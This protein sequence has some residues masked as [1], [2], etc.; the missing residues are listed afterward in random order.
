MRV[1][2][3]MCVLWF[4]EL[5]HCIKNGKDRI[6]FWITRSLGVDTQLPHGA[7]ISTGGKGEMVRLEIK[8][9]LFRHGATCHRGVTFSAEP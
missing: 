5:L 6:P 9:M 1:Y 3:N 2:K 4:T 7:Y 8:Y